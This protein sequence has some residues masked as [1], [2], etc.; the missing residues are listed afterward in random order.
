MAYMN[1]VD[2]DVHCPRKAIETVSP[3]DTL[4]VPSGADDMHLI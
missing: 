2:P 1:Y 4:Q 3:E